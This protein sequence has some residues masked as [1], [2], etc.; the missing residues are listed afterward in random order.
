MLYS[1]RASVH[2]SLTQQFYGVLELLRSFNSIKD[3]LHN[4]L[5]KWGLKCLK[6]NSHVLTPKENNFRINFLRFTQVYSFYSTVTGPMLFNMSAEYVGTMLSSILETT[7]FSHWLRRCQL[8]S[9]T[10]PRRLTEEISTSLSESPRT[11]C[12]FIKSCF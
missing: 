11:L 4:I 3:D 12:S 9:N 8:T 7:V 1:T 6:R 5:K 10:I 2:Y